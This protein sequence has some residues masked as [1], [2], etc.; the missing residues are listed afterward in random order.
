MANT[1]FMLKD[2]VPFGKGDEQELLKEVTLGSLTV[3][4]ITKAQEESEKLVPTPQGYALIV[5]PTLVGLNLLRYQIKQLGRVKGPL[6]LAMMHSLTPTDL[7]LLNQKADALDAAALKGVEQRG[8]D[9]PA[10]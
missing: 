3:G 5:S 8:R 9:Q 4:D 1:T 2:G 7:D 6:S 10:P